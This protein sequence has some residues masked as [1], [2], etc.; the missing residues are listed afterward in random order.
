MNHDSDQAFLGRGRRKSAQIKQAPPSLRENF[1]ALQ[2]KSS[3]RSEGGG[4]RSDTSEGKKPCFCPSRI[5][6]P[7][8]GKGS[9]HSSG[10]ENQLFVV[11]GAK[12]R[13]LQRG[14]GKFHFEGTAKEEKQK[15]RN[16]LDRVIPSIGGKIP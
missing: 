8:M 2:E 15:G 9:P 11:K 4:R 3:G 5:S 6:S 14:E 1:S 16:Q 7:G 10:A 13:R 12:S